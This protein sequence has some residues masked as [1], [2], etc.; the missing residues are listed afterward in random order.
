MEIKKIEKIVYNLVKKNRKLKNILRNI[1]QIL[2][3]PRNFF[4]DSLYINNDYLDLVSY[5]DNSYF[6]FHDRPSVNSLGMVINHTNYH[7][8]D[9]GEGEASLFI[10]YLDNRAP[11]NLGKTRCFNFQQGSLATWIDDDTIIYNTES[12]GI[13]KV[14]I[15]CLGNGS[16]KEF[17]FHYN[18]VSPNGKYLTVTNFLRYGRGL[19]GYGYNI[20]FPLEYKNDAKDKLGKS[21]LSDL[22]IFDVDLNKEVFR[23]SIS[24]ARK[25]SRGLIESGYF[26]FSHSSFSQD[27]NKVYFL[28]RS[29]N[30]RYNSSQLFS[31]D[32]ETSNLVSF[33][34]NGM[35]SHLSWADNFNIIA[36]ANT[37]NFPDGYYRF[38]LSTGKGTAILPD[39]LT[40]D[41]HPNCL[42]KKVFF[43]DTYANVMRRQKLK[44]VDL[45]RNLSVDICD[46][47][48]PFRFRDNNRV[49][50]H[51]RLSLC[52]KYLSIDSSY[53]GY[54]CQLIFKLKD[55]IME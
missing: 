35:V 37:I 50:L 19:S 33:D 26:Y 55:K 38:D 6:G 47:Y 20:D 54:R 42:D 41:G 16:K 40:V 48:S 14:N 17:D 3:I 45:E 10:S 51:P 4:I 8:N 18:S 28:L 11:L 5:Y 32:I 44:F 31:Y 25:K 24:E 13:P 53:K 15:I 22:V 2:N 30:D 1:Y 39:I 52:K 29:S 27:S 43:T 23:I 12:D 21:S 36:Y 7:V 49:D 46:L 9:D 34:T